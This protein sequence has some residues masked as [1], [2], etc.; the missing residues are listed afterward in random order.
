MVF[1]IAFSKSVITA[2]FLA[3]IL[4]NLA[5]IG[6][7][8]KANNKPPRV[9]GKWGIFKNSLKKCRQHGIWSLRAR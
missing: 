1:K 7:K 6:N 4:L 2:I 8:N 9:V 5:R 3:F